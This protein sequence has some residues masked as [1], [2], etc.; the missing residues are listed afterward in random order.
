MRRIHFG[1]FWKVNQEE[2]RFVTYTD[3]EIFAVE[4][5]FGPFI[6]KY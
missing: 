2:L 3:I 1:T 5:N 4:I 6:T